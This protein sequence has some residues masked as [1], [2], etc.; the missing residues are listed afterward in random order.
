MLGTTAPLCFHAQDRRRRLLSAPLP[1]PTLP[2]NSGHLP[3]QMR[4]GSQEDPETLCWQVCW[5]P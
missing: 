4:R 1:P 2:E 3:S 5:E